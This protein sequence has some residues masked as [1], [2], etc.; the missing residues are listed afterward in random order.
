MSQDPYYVPSVCFV[1]IMKLCVDQLILLAPS[2]AG[3]FSFE[4]TQFKQSHGK[5]DLLFLCVDHYH[6]ILRSLRCD[7]LA[8]IPEVCL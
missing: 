3:I 4:I 7:F 1:T 2:Q 8:S 6:D 5:V